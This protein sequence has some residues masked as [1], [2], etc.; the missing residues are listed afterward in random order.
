MITTMIAATIFLV[1]A[2][3][4]QQL[5]TQ[6]LLQSFLVYI[7]CIHAVAAMHCCNS[8]MLN[9]FSLPNHNH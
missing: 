1:A 2:Q 6:L 8:C 3:Q 5:F 4:L 9:A 7:C